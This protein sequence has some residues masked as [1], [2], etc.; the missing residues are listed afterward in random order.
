MGNILKTENPNEKKKIIS[1]IYGLSN[2]IAMTVIGN[3]IG[4]TLDRIILNIKNKENFHILPDKN[5]IFDKR[6]FSSISNLY[7]ITS[8]IGGFLLHSARIQNIH[9]ITV[10]FLT[11][12][13]FLYNL[14][15]IDIPFF[16]I[17]LLMFSFIVFY[18]GS[19]FLTLIPIINICQYIPSLRGFISS[20]FI[21]FGDFIVSIIIW[22][23]YPKK[24]II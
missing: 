14:P 13:V 1:I 10:L 19:G 23:F 5:D 2:S 17:L 15:N 7:N 6:T 18:C 11:L 12:F 9:F 3:L 4:S 20:L 21:I 22:I 8:F 24:K 16:D